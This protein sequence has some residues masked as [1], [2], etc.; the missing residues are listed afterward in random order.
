VVPVPMRGKTVLFLIGEAVGGSHAL[1]IP[2]LRRHA[3]MTALA[4][5]ILALRK[6]LAAL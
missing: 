1:Q 4:L 3:S 2:V 6:K 5:E